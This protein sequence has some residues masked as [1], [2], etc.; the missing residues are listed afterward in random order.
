MLKN[1]IIKFSDGC[2]KQTKKLYYTKNTT[3]WNVVR[4]PI[5]THPLS[6]QNIKV[7]IKTANEAR[8]NGFT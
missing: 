7:E 3:T 1:F 8:Q 2:K 4:I 6:Y 5:Q